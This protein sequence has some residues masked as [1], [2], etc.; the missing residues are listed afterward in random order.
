[1]ISINNLRVSDRKTGIHF[2]GIRA[3]AGLFGGL[4]DLIRSERL[5][6]VKGFVP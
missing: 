6:A 3:K 5:L 4:V 1:M 2:C